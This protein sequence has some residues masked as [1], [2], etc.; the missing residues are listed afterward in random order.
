MRTSV[1]LFCD[2]QHCNQSLRTPQLSDDK[3]YIELPM[4]EE[5]CLYDKAKTV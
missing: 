1:V 2:L 5:N 4:L 3:D